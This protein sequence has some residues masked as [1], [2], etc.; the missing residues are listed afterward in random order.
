MTAALLTFILA[1]SLLVVLPGPD[2]L[3]VLRSILLRGRRTAVATCAGVLTGLAVW[4]AAAALGLSALLRASELGYTVL[5]L[6]G[7]LYLIALGVQALRSARRV[8]A[9]GA[10]QVGAEQ[11]AAQPAAREQMAAEPAARKQVAGRSGIL[12]VGYRAGLVT[13]LLNP[14]VGVFFVTFLPGFVPRGAPIGATS[15]LFGA[16]FVAEGALYFAILLFLAERVATALR[17]P[18]VRRR[19][20]RLTGV[21]LI[22]FGIRLA[23]ES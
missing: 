11:V 1:A 3:L 6:A 18:T 15:L 2:S 17:R 21:V 10:E 14:K 16:V 19:L 8:T 5:R 4:V 7:G 9:A 23:A 13:N 12:G 22:G 20:D